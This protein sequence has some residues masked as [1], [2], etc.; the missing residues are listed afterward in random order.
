[1]T[2]TENTTELVAQ[3][4]DDN[5]P[6]KVR[7]V[8]YFVLLVCAAVVLLVQ[9]LAPIWLEPALA[10]KAVASAGVVTAVLG[11]IA[12]GLGVAYRPTR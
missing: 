8:A 6:A 2:D 1:V 4:V 11:L 12:G 7:T 9:G 3:F 10:D 5:V